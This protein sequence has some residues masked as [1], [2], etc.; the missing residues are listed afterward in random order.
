MLTPCRS[1]RRHVAVADASCPFCGAAVTHVAPQSFARASRAPLLAV[2]AAAAIAGGDD[3]KKAEPAPVTNVAAENSAPAPSASASVVATA[4]ASASA[5]A[6]DSL[7]GLGSLD[8]GGPI[9]PGFGQGTMAAAYGGPPP[10]GGL[11]AIGPKGDVMTGASTGA[12]A[13][14][15]VDRVIATSRPRLRSC[16]NMALNSDP[17]AEGTVKL[18]ISIDTTGAVS[19]VKV[20]S[21]TAPAVVAS[22]VTAAVKSLQFKPP[23]QAGTVTVPLTFKPKS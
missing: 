11:A 1:C 23:K 5:S 16:Y 17:G 8:L 4:S 12:L 22:C 13:S 3:K 6:A 20:V 21:S 7:D 2:A 14:S 10:P 9:K 19:A 18:A 15:E